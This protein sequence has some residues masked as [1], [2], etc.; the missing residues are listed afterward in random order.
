MP[1]EDLTGLRRKFWRWLTFAL[2]VV[3]GIN[4]Y[5]HIQSRSDREK[6]KED[7]KVQIEHDEA[8]LD[9]RSRVAI[10]LINAVSNGRSFTI[11]ERKQIRELWGKAKFDLIQ[12]EFIEPSN[13]KAESSS[14]HV[15]Q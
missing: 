11:D 2:L 8:V 12:K 10:N 3:M 14:S 6:I 5:F 1:F 15:K 9:A 4:M 13:V 7:M